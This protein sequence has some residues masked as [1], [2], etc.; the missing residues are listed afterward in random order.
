MNGKMVFRRV[1]Y[2]KTKTS[3][4]IF[5][6]L[7]LCSCPLG[8]IPAMG[9]LPTAL[10]GLTVKQAIDRF[11]TKINSSIQVAGQQGNFLVENAGRKLDLATQNLDYI[12]S[13]NLDKLA[14]TISIEEQRVLAE[15]DRLVQELD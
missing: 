10:A 6:L 8:K 14:R 1:I 9:L 15:M 7:M 13:K 2:R 5:A 11:H 4:G 3:A 12:L